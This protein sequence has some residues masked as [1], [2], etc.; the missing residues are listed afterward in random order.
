MYSILLLAVYSCW[1][2][3]EHSHSYNLVC[4]VLG[5]RSLIWERLVVKSMEIFLTLCYQVGETMVVEGQQHRTQLSCYRNLSTYLIINQT[6]RE[7]ESVSLSFSHKCLWNKLA[8]VIKLYLYRF[9]SINYFKN[10][11]SDYTV[12]T[13]VLKHFF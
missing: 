1:Y 11:F 8:Y 6:L 4:S 7:M 3:W 12:C 9:S 13:L 2:N 10:I 5:M